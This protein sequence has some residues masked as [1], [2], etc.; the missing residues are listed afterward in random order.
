LF[1]FI[2][3]VWRNF[4]DEETGELWISDEPADDKTRKRLHY[5]IKRVD[6]AMHSL[7]FNTAIAAIIELN[8][9][10]AK[11][12]ER[13]IATVGGPAHVEPTP[14]SKA[15]EK[16][17]REVA[18]PLVKLLAP[19]VPHVAEELW[20][21]MGR[22]GDREDARSSIMYQ[23]FPEADPR[24]LK[25]DEIQIAVQVLGKVRAQ[26]T[27]SPDADEESV[28]ALALADDNVKRHLEGK[29]IRKVIFV[30]GRLMNFVAN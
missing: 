9:G 22:R 5:T 27:V 14:A 18:E 4:I 12:W 6:D 23:P 16:T 8:N 3:K 20:E 15:R 11:W 10:L 28:K 24:Y 1:R 21:R 25:V 26:L 30:P 17:P 19:F 13:S 2:Q 7:S 29:T